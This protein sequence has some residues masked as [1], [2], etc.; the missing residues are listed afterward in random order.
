MSSDA[1]KLPVTDGPE[2]VEF[3]LIFL[4]IFKAL[5][6]QA[7]D[8]AQECTDAIF[9]LSASY[10]NKPAF[11]ALKRFYELYFGSGDIEAS[12]ERINQEVDDLV[13]SLQEKISA[14]ESLDDVETGAEY[15]QERLGLAGVQK[16]L[17]SLITLDSGIKQQILP[18]LTT[19]QFEDA[20]NQ[21]LEHVKSAWSKFV[22]YFAEGGGFNQDAEKVA[23]EMA[24]ACSSVDEAKTFYRLILDEEPPEGYET[25]SIFLEF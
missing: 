8:G 23:R 9:K 17:E 12:K 3:D 19:M 2:L 20:I 24:E 13:A 10:V 18:A 11:D 14:G 7:L 22:N 21:R 5:K 4:S 25:R 1:K 6:A 15:E 16:Q